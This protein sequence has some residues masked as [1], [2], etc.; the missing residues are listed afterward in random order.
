MLLAQGGSNKLGKSLASIGLLYGES[1]LT[2]VGVLILVLIESL[3]FREHKHV[4]LSDKAKFW[5]MP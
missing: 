3:S 1:V 4:L 2:K 5:N